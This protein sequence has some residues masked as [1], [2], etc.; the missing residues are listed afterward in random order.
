[1][2][3]VPCCSPI[4]A[5]AL[6]VAP[7]LNGVIKRSKAGWQNRQGPGILQPWFDL[8]KYLGRE[9]VVSEHASWL[10]RWAPY[11]YFAAHLAAAALVPTLVLASP[12]C[13]DGRRRSCW[14]ACSLWLAS[15]WRW[16]RWTPP[17]TSAGWAPAGSW[18]SPPWWSRRCSSPSS[19]WPFPPARR[20]WARWWAMGSMSVARL[21]ALGGA[22]HRRHS[23][24]GA[25]PRRQ[26]GY[27]PGADHGPRGHAAGVLRPSAGAAPLGHPHQAVGHALAAGG[28]VFPWGM[29]RDASALSLALGLGS[30]PAEADGCWAWPSL[31]SRAPTSSCASSGCRSCWARRACSGCWRSPLSTW[32]EARH[33]P[34]RFP[35]RPG[36]VGQSGAPSPGDGPGLG[37]A[38]AAGELRS[39]CWP[40]RECCWRPRPRWS[41]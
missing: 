13:G 9:S 28:P 10:F 24:D 32:W 39:G 23:R 27:A 5:L 38:P 11:V 4:S 6:V 41:P 21:L 16:P 18:P 20:S 7:L 19:P 1:M 37:A 40:C 34:S 17:A 2:V 31:W 8:W 33:D 3:N 35:G 36:P 12:L 25:D 29:A 30:L 15:P 26:P 14:S 22:L